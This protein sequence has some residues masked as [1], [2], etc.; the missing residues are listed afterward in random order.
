V[1]SVLFNYLDETATN[2]HWRKLDYPQHGCVMIAGNAKRFWHIGQIIADQNSGKFY[3]LHTLS[4]SALSVATELP[5]LAYTFLDIT[6]IEF[7][8]YDK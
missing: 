2:K 1:P 6:N 8:I 4:R 7:Y 5:R 3:V